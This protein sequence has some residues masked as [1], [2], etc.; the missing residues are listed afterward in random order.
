[1]YTMTKKQRRTMQVVGI[2]TI[3]ALVIGMVAPLLN[4]K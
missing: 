4:L 1:M 2:L 3:T